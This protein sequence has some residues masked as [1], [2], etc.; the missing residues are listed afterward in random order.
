MRF[1]SESGQSTI[2]A[3][4]LFPI[5]LTA[6][7]LL[8]QPAI[9]LYNHCIMNAAAAEGCRLLA[10][11]TASDANVRAY[12]ER[13]LG[14]IPKLAIFH[15]GDTWDIQWANSEDGMSEVC[16]TNRAEPLPLFG[17]IAGLSNNIGADGKIEQQIK[18]SCSPV[19]KWIANQGY[20]PSSWIGEWK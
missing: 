14:S 19:P 4:M 10:T 5:L 15:Q 9:L 3:A 1:F 8:L 16:I 11:N 13:R 2:E 20:S 6:F 12:I 7:A 17:I 18:I